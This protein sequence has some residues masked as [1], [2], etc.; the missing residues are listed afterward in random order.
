MF[1]CSN[2]VDIINDLMPAVAEDKPEQLFEAWERQS[3]EFLS[4]NESAMIYD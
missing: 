2:D 4:A 3:I 1:T